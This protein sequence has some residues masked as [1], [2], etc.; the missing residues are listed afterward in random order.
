MAKQTNILSKVVKLTKYFGCGTKRTKFDMDVPTL[1]ALIPSSANTPFLRYFFLNPPHPH[2]HLLYLLN[3]IS[4]T[5]R[6]IGI[7]KKN[8]DC[9]IPSSI[10]V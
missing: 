4:V 9:Y 3:V 10:P 1:A 5:R 8:Y 6:W 2:T 7:C